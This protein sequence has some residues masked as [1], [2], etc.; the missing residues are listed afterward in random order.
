MTFKIPFTNFAP[1]L[2]QVIT[3]C[4]A[5]LHAYT[6]LSSDPDQMK[7]LKR[8][9]KKL[10]H[11]QN[12]EKV[13][14]KRDLTQPVASATDSAAASETESERLAKKRKLE[15]QKRSANDMFGP[16]LVAERTKH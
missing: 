4:A 5:L 14:L 10:Y 13:N 16:E 3:D 15:E 12:P 6:P 8:I 11:C 9:A 2:L 7:S 1:K